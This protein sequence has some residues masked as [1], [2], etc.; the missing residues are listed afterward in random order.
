MSSFDPYGVHSAKAEVR[1][2]LERM[3][4]EAEERLANLERLPDGDDYAN[5]AVIRVNVRHRRGDEIHTY[6]FLKVMTPNHTGRTGDP[7]LDSTSRFY[8]RWYFT[9]RLQGVTSDW[10]TWERLVRW[11]TSDVEIVSW[12]E[13]VRKRGDETMINVESVVLHNDYVVTLP[14][15]VQ[16]L[17]FNRE[18]GRFELP[19]LPNEDGGCVGVNSV[20]LDNYDDLPA[21]S[22]RL[23]HN[24]DTG[25]FE[26]AP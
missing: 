18:H 24:L 23:K 5:G 7:G 9:G 22:F 26:V 2:R 8:V 10:I 4:R 11:A 20:F 16:R 3:A 21:G 14:R 6:V 1:A 12:E 25:H 15:G 13:L 17:K 19:N